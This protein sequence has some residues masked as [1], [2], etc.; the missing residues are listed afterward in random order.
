MRREAER[1]E[2]RAK[3]RRDMAAGLLSSSEGEEEDDDDE[4]GLGERGGEESVGE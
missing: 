4:V 1:V 3:E 2:P